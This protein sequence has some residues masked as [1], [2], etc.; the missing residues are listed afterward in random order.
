M[1]PKE[2]ILY[3]LREYEA[4]NYETEDF[5]NEYTQI[6]NIE[7][8]Y[9]SLSEAEYESLEEL[10][11]FTARFSPFEE[12]LKIINVYYD[13]K[14]VREKTRELIKKLNISFKK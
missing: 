10:S 2:K 3:L 9:D 11:N 14:Q 8:D 13:E 6:F 4:G 5:C 7:L 1:N 12:D